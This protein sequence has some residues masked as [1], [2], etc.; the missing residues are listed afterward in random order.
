MILNVRDENGKFIPIPA[1]KGQDGKDAPADV[2]RYG[3]QTLNDAQKA[4][5]RENIG[6]AEV[7]GKFE[8]IETI[9]LE[10]EVAEIVRDGY[11]LKGVI[12][13]SKTA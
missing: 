3:V 5:A 7:E 1:I 9:T 10:E 4:Q 8:L 13:Q 6:A 12:V 11:K 2:V